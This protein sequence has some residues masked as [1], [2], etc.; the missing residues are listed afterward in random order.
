MMMC[1]SGGTAYPS[2]SS[3]MSLC[4]CTGSTVAIWVGLG[5]AGSATTME[6]ACTTP[7]RRAA[8]QYGQHVG[9]VAREAPRR[10]LELGEHDN[11]RRRIAQ[12]S[13]GGQNSLSVARSS[14]TRQVA[15]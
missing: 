12:T 11:H 6:H 2:L 5:M 1:C 7:M 8:A 15:R 9:L 4:P 13:G 14:T 10:H 3:P